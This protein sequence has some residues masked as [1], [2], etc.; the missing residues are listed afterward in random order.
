MAA[1]T[2]A[3][4]LAAGGSSRL[5]RPKQL[6]T[7]R[8]GSLLRHAIDCAR[9]AGCDPVLV[10]LGAEADRIAGDLEGSGV[11]IVIHEGW[12]AGLASSIRAGVAAARRRVPEPDAVMLIACD[13]PKL[14]AGVVRELRE[15]VESGRHP[16]AACRYDGTVGVPAAF[17]R[18]LFGELLQLE[19]S[20]GAKSIL[21]S[22]LEEAHCVDWPDGA[23]DVDRP[24]DLD[25]IRQD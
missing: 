15:S 18:P 1:L 12:Q 19:G 2:A 24:E 6:V 8:G 17:H 23:I 3:V 13:Q 4:V 7:H 5:G 16:L 25:A 20:G 10:V 14:T 9:R 11:T 21:E 22:R